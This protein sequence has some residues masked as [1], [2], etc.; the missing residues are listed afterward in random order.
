MHRATREMSNNYLHSAITQEIIGK[1]MKI[2]ASLGPGLLESAYERCLE[3]ELVKSGFDVKSQVLLP[4]KYEELEIQ[5]AYRLDLLVEQKVVVEVK[6]VEQIIDKHEA[7]LLTYLRL[8][9]CQVGLIINFY[10]KKLKD[11]L[12]R[13]VL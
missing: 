12:K 1:A 9:G 8:T 10:E 2:H 5:Q 4:L 7:Q 3:Y 13:F 11:G 6:A